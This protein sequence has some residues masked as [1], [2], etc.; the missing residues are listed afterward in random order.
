MT[1][2]S[3][4]LPQRQE[5]CRLLFFEDVPENNRLTFWVS[6]YGLTPKADDG[7]KSVIFS[8]ESS[9]CFTVGNIELRD[10]AQGEQAENGLHFPQRTRLK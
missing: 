6:A 5:Q 3:L 7:K 9:E 10:S 1:L 2:T 8:S 4:P